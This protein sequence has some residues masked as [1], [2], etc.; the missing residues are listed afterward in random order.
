MPSSL[1]IACRCAE[2]VVLRRRDLLLSRPPLWARENLA[3][4]SDGRRAPD[5]H[6]DASR[7]PHGVAGPRGAVRLTECASAPGRT[8][9]H[10]AHDL[11]RL[12]VGRHRAP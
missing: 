10:Q 4:P 3:D 12:S 9:P 2:V 7:D 6:R 1:E 8:R 5:D 11:P